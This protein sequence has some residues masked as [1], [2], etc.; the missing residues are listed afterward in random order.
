M[1]FEDSLFLPK[2]LK[3]YDLRASN[4]RQLELQRGLITAINLSTDSINILDAMAKAAGIDD[5]IRKIDKDR[6]KLRLDGIF[7]MPIALGGSLLRYLERIQLSTDA[8]EFMALQWDAITTLVLAL[9]DLKSA[10]GRGAS[11]VLQA[12]KTLVFG[13]CDLDGPIT[14]TRRMTHDGKMVSTRAGVNPDFVKDLYGMR[15]T[16]IVEQIRLS[17]VQMNEANAVKHVPDIIQADVCGIY[18]LGMNGAAPLCRIEDK[19]HIDQYHKCVLC[20]G[21]HP[22]FNCPFLRCM[23][24]LTPYNPYFSNQEFKDS[25]LPQKQRRQPPP[26]TPKNRLRGDNAN[27]NG[28]PN[29]SNK[30]NNNNPNKGPNKD[31]KK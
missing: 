17:Q 13:V 16:P 19:T 3:P 15:V 27:K 26:F 4:V 10:N 6:N 11:R 22:V 24:R 29:N 21:R 20:S 25:R 23:M 1:L 5:P 30:N 8:N 18:Q 31:K 28:A 9:V 2:E 12:Y 14:Y 7:D